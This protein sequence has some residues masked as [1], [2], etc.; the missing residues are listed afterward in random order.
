M[1]FRDA[2]HNESDETSLAIELDSTPPLPPVVARLR[3]VESNPTPDDP[4]RVDR[5]NHVF[6]LSSEPGALVGA[7]AIEIA[8]DAS[9]A[10]IEHSLEA[11]E[12][13][14]FGEVSLG[15]LPEDGLVRWSLR[16]VDVAGNRSEGV[17]IS[18]VEL[19]EIEVEPELSRAGAEPVIVRFG[20]SA[21]LLD[22]PDVRVA[23]RTLSCD[24]DG[25]QRWACSFVPDGSEPE[26]IAAAI[27]RIDASDG[28]GVLAPGSATT[29]A[30]TLSLDFEAPVIDE[31]KVRI[32]AVGP[33]APDRWI[34]EAGAFS[35]ALSAADALEA[36][37]TT[38]DGA[39]ELSRGTVD[40][41]GALD[42]IDIGDNAVTRARLEVCDPAGNC[43]SVEL[44]N[45]VTP[46]DLGGLT[47]DPPLA[48]DSTP[49]SIRF[50]LSDDLSG[51]GD[52]PLVTLGGRGA[53]L[54]SG[55]PIGAQLDYEL[56][57]DVNLDA[58]GEVEVRVVARD[59]A[60]NEAVITG[61]LAL[62]LV[63]PQS[64][65][66]VPPR[67][68]LWNGRPALRGSAAD[69]LTAVGAV[70]VALQEAASGLYW[71]GFGFSSAFPQWE[72]AQGI[73]PF[74]A[75]LPLES[76]TIG[77]DYVVHHRAIDFAGNVEGPFPTR[78]FTMGDPALEAPF[79]LVAT[80]VGEARVE[81]SWSAP[82]GATPIA[83]DV[84]YGV[85][86]SSPPYT[87][88]GAEA[89]DSPVRVDAS[90]LGLALT[91]LPRGRYRFAVSA[92]YEHEARSA[93]SASVE[94][95]SRSW[96]WRHPLATSNSVIAFASPSEDVII[97]VGG[98][99]TIWRS[100]DSGESWVPTPAPTAESLR[101][102]WGSGDVVVA[103]GDADIV[104]SADGGLTWRRSRIEASGS[105]RN[106]NAIAGEG[107]SVFIGLRGRVLVSHDGGASFVD[108]WAEF[109]YITFV[110]SAAGKDGHFAFGGD[111]S[112]CV[113]TSDGGQ[114]WQER[115]TAIPHGRIGRL[116]SDGVHFVASGERG[117]V[118][119]SH[120]GGESWVPVPS[121]TTEQLLGI[122]EVEGALLM[123]SDDG[124]I[125]RST[126]YGVTWTKVRDASGT[127]THLHASGSRVIGLSRHGTVLHSEDG[128][129]SFEA[130]ATMPRSGGTHLGA[131]GDRIVLGGEDGFVVTSQDFG[132]SW[133][134]HAPPETRELRDVWARDDF[135]IAVGLQGE[136][137]LTLDGGEVW[138]RRAIEG[139]SSRVFQAVSGDDEVVLA[140]GPFAD[141]HRSDDRGATWTAVEAAEGASWA[142]IWGDGARWVVVGNSGE[143][144]LSVDDGE[145]WTAATA[146][147]SGRRFIAVHGHGDVVAAVGTLGLLSVSD[148]GGSSW[149]EIDTALSRN[150]EAVWVAADIA[151]AAGDASNVLRSTDGGE[152]WTPLGGRPQHDPIDL[153]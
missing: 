148:D 65:I 117:A 50:T 97:A 116:W 124:L 40:A 54:M 2:L 149:S 108:G 31:S 111:A 136:V 44:D 118:S 72:R 73:A 150:L 38:G 95:S 85:S 20:S 32:D 24:P 56:I 53:T 28:R 46:P 146:A 81:L 14:D 69:A 29:G 135:G 110:M 91:S 102:V 153:G 128:G 60:G 49:V 62:D 21:P 109:P 84:F 126:D 103:A 147:P 55:Q 122:I 6:H 86:E 123:W 47:I 151:L 45:D 140:T 119:I 42:A 137:L 15:A 77:A 141:V 12:S 8:R 3:L 30:A 143:A 19:F 98:G 63:P 100:D 13:G 76:L 144:A 25:F 34:S 132:A 99:G 61:S 48:G 107:S 114:T 23:E 64:V 27:V 79:D 66:E 89:G 51:V 74:T 36:V 125:I 4:S 78:A 37:L 68:G 26:G 16:A 17:E 105:V 94:A 127:L 18:G 134:A 9:F 80:S 1:R 130:G 133:S 35:D 152:T 115:E 5:A 75:S 112:L 113:Q 57:T 106:A 138:E 104:Y 67:D 10:T 59:D 92:V 93:W 88:F 52:P 39:L 70:E 145:S 22:L 82:A 83:Y 43:A 129:L 139:A 33:G 120:D 131:Q 58:E 101:V 7:N 87:G 142:A 41:S 11:S 121:R 96:A 71:D 90:T